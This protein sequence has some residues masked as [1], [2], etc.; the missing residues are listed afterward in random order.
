[1][2][3]EEYKSLIDEMGS[4]RL[5]KYYKCYRKSGFPKEYFHCMFKEYVE[6]RKR[7]SMNSFT[8]FLF[9]FGKED[10]DVEI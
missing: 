10:K 8:I 9:D 3:V 2:D 5:Q 1:M 4:E 6:S 7:I